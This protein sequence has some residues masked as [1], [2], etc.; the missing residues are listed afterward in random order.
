MQ[1][2]IRELAIFYSRENGKVM[3]KYS[4][5]DIKKYEN[6]SINDYL[7][8]NPHLFIKSLASCGLTSIE[9]INT[10]VLES[11][12]DVSDMVENIPIVTGVKINDNS[13]GK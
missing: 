13:L 4:L 12:E 2:I 11:L 6:K 5:I 8:D 9:A 7:Q 3:A 10:Y 1:F